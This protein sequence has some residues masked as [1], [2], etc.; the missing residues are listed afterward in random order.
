MAS[1]LTSQHD[2]VGSGTN[3]RSKNA[4]CCGKWLCN[5]DLYFESIVM[6][7]LKVFALFKCIEYSEKLAAQWGELYDRSLLLNGPCGV[8]NL[9]PS[10]A[11]YTPEGCPKINAYDMCEIPESVLNSAL[12]ARKMREIELAKAEA[13]KAKTEAEAEAAANEAET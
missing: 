8:Y 11:A 10:G 1:K 3:S 5:K 9:T 4:G 13:A 2:E 6:R 7:A 12:Y